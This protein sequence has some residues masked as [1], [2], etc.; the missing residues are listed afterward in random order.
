LRAKP[1]IID[2]RMVDIAVA[3]HDKLEDPLLNDITVAK[4][5]G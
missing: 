2:V 5:R 1:T 4:Y 3:A